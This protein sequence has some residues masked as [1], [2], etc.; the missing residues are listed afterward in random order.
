MAAI[1]SAIIIEIFFDNNRISWFT[2]C[3]FQ[4]TIN[5]GQLI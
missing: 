4:S 3:L 5:S 1:R 2:L